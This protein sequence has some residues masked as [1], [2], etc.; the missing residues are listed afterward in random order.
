MDLKN[1][2]LILTI[3]FLVGIWGIFSNRK[4]IRIVAMSEKIKKLRIWTSC[5]TPTSILKLAFRYM[6]MVW[7]LSL[8]LS[9]SLN[10]ISNLTI[11]TLVFLAI[12]MVWLL[13]LLLSVPLLF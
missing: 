12:V 1:I 9:V 10:F 6:V 7:L 3:L 4:N 13:L 5:R 8:L 11:F 2:L